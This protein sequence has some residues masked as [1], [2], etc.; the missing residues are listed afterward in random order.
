MDMIVKPIRGLQ[1]SVMGPEEIRSQ[2][3]VEITK[4]ET[5]EKDVPVI[6]GLF[7]LRLGTT[8]IGKMCNTCGQ[9][10]SKCPGHFGHIELAR[11]I[12]HYHFIGITTKL[13]KCICF[14]CSKLL[15]NKDDPF[16]QSVSQR[17][18]KI[19]WKEICDA[20]GKINR[21]GQDTEEGCGCQQP[22]RYRVDGIAGIEAIWKNLGDSGKHTQHLEAEYVKALFEGIAEE[23]YLLLGF[24]PRWCKPEWL[25]CTVLPV[26]PP[27]V[28]PSVK[29]QGDSQRMEDDLTHKF[30]D[31]LK[32]NNG[33]KSKMEGNYRAEIIKDWTDMVQYHVATMVDNEISGV[34]PASYKQSGRP[35][36]SIRQRLKGKEGRIRSNLMGK[37]VD[38]SARSVITPDPNLALDELGVPNAIA[39]NLTYPD[40]VNDHNR[41]RLQRLVANGPKT[42]PGAKSVD[43]AGNLGTYT[44]SEAH[45]PPE[46]V[47]GDIVHR[48]LCDG[49]YVLFNRQ[50]SLHKMSMM[51]HRV[52][53]MK[54]NTFRL[55]VSVTP[56]YNAD[57]D[58]DEMNLHAPQSVAAVSEL[59]NIASVNHQIISPR[60]NKPIITIV[61]DTLLGIY[62]LTHA[63]IIRFPKGSSLHYAENTNL[64][65]VD[66]QSST[67]CV[68]SCVFTRS[69]M[70]NIVCDLSTFEGIP[71]ESDTTITVQGK[72]IKMWSGHNILSFILPDTV[73]LTMANGKYD[74]IQDATEETED[75][76]SLK[77][78][79]AKMN[80]VKIVNGMVQQGTFD[81]SMFSKTSQGLIHTICNDLGPMRAHHLINDL[82]KIVSYILLI[83]GFSVGISDMIADASTTEKI[84]AV[85]TERKKDIEEIVQE[86]HLNIFESL[87]GKS[88]R[89]FFE[90]KVNS[91]LNKTIK[92]TGKIGLASLDAKNRTTYMVNSGSKGKLINISQMVACLGQQNVDGARIPYGFQGRT[93]PHYYKYDDSPEARGFVENSFISGQTPQE[94]YFHAM[95]GREGLID[96][97]VKTA[98]TGYVQRQLVKS[99]EDLMVAHDYSV[100]TSGGTIVQFVYGNDGMD[101]TFVESQP[102]YLTKVTLEELVEKFYF[103]KD[104][105]WSKYLQ[106]D[107]VS[108]VTAAVQDSLEDSFQLLLNHR[109]YLLKVVF[110]D[111]PES[112]I[113]FPVHI[114]RI[115][116]NLCLKPSK[117][118]SNVSPSEILSR[119]AELKESLFVREGFENNKIFEILIDVHLS[120]KVLLQ[121]YKITSSEYEE[122]VRIIRETYESSRISPGEM[123]GVLAAQSIGEP[124]TQMTL[125]TFH[126]AGVGSKSNVTRGIP[127][128]K[129]LIHVSKNM[130]SPLTKICLLPGYS[131]EES[132]SKFVKNQLEYTILKDILQ[133]SSLYYDPKH[134]S[135]GTDITED[136][137]LLALYKDFLEL[138]ETYEES[139]APLC[140][141]IVRMIFNKEIMMDKGITMEDIS[142]ALMGYDKDKLR[143]IFTDENSKDLVGRLSLNMASETAYV[144]GIQDQSDIIA[145]FQNINEDLIHNVVIKGIQ[146]IHDITLSEHT[147]Y[148]MVDREIQPVSEFILESDG[149]N[150]IPIMNSEYTQSSECYSNDII[151][152]LDVLGIEA[153]RNLLM[154]EILEVVEHADEYINQRHLE[155]L[156]DIMTSRGL[157]VSINR[158][159]INRGEVGP[160]GRC[161]FEDTTDQLIKAS[162]FSELDGL[163][164]V[165]SNIMMGQTIRAGTGLAD[166][167]LDETEL[168][169]LMKEYKD[170]VVKSHPMNETVL[171]NYLEGDEEEEEACAYE[172]FLF[173]FE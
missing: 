30:A 29:K 150:L 141:W 152:V 70:M 41:E 64:Y 54:G 102:L 164:G 82:Q 157:L 76:H 47:N 155:V 34:S 20:S 111:Y 10:N 122:V 8:E 65:Q 78:Y 100:R 90:G 105:A 144:N 159:G 38:F 27:A 43:K 162:I 4:N 86:V 91:L 94:F 116:E 2:S 173:S 136:Q 31:I 168:R 169:H 104:T 92:D 115:V 172:D 63:E 123:V 50:P 17:D 77:A 126:F 44:L 59:I 14:R 113:T 117:P 67:Q 24:H 69:Q 124:A 16:I 114:K 106:K 129:E 153:T 146:G 39:M 88:K 167:L 9:K 56:P 107:L 66:P 135:Y 60:E 21:C 97:A 26:P 46:L 51:G 19:R 85:I 22:D 166:I 11:P 37:R 83:D 101:A 87:P 32:Y 55:N 79:N 18:P 138:D 110:D 163:D 148:Q 133:E 71:P 143:F 45:T 57:F 15:V 84:N 160:L 23:D 98:S 53:V 33:L 154:K 58:G 73:N 103:P 121:E 161:S 75:P 158:Q 171:V 74:A 96:T 134:T 120:P 81:K 80:V 108:S 49:D 170:D 62:K 125:N 149:V 61:Q 130:K 112:H 119:N 28:R 93:L 6:K 13:L 145:T 52:K 48:H 142:L 151:E 40:K 147:G 68:N 109:M 42:W 128:L 127:R 140:P 5:Y 89:E 35:L 156:C 99:M 3:V 132:K 7:D 12:Y 36:K 165:S 1:F 72:E 95:A 118:K 131:T 137:E 139:E 25:I